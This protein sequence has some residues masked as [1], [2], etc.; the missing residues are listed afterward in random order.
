MPNTKNISSKKKIKF[1]TLFFSLIWV[2]VFAGCSF[3]NSSQEEIQPEANATFEREWIAYLDFMNRKVANGPKSN[4]RFPNLWYS[5]YV[6]VCWENPTSQNHLFRDIVRQAVANTWEAFSA[7]R[8]HGWQRCSKAQSDL[9]ILISDQGPHTKGLGSQLKGKRAGL[10]LNDTY[11]SWGKSCQKNWNSC[12]Y[13]IA[14]HE[15]GHVL[16]FAHEQNRA[17]TPGE[18][19]K[20]AQGD[21]GSLIQL[22]PWD[23]HSV[24]NYCNPIRN[25]D[26]NLS[27]WDKF[28]LSKTYGAF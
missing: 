11:N 2:L 3:E 5:K 14:V 26:G 28:T 8:F 7:I 24:M 10:V 9:R 12:S 6:S 18:C 23:S 27:Q 22:T 20:L 1:L 25:N 4:L 19:S 16:G 21:N 13:S 17:D 15:F